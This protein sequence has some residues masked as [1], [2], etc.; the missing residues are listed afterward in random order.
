MICN[1]F[2]WLVLIEVIEVLLSEIFLEGVF[3]IY[4]I[5]KQISGG[6]L[7]E[8]RI[9]VTHFYNA[10]LVLF[11]QSFVLRFWTT[12]LIHI[13]KSWTNRC[14]RTRSV[15][16]SFNFAFFFSNCSVYRCVGL[17]LNIWAIPWGRVVVNFNYRWKRIRTHTLFEW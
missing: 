6:I 3:I 1:G 7:V 4:I 9:L 5:Y 13:E 15:F 16:W 11:M 2:P 14:C 8:L 17:L 10:C 12:T